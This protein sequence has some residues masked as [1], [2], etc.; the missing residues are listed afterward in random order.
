M[1]NRYI[2]GG[3]PVLLAGRELEGARFFM[4][5]VGGWTHLAVLLEDGRCFGT[6]FSDREL[7][8]DGYQNFCEASEQHITGRALYPCE[9]PVR[10]PTPVE[11][12]T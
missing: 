11:D 4:E 3:K 9:T 5:R 10:L 6:E 2:E 1:P 8:V 7:C 12:P